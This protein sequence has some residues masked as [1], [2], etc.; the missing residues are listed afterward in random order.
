[1]ELAV[2]ES[3][4]RWH[5]LG[6][7]LSPNGYWTPSGLESSVVLL[8]LQIIKKIG[9]KISE[10]V[11]AETGVVYGTLG[12]RLVDVVGNGIVWSFVPDPELR[13]ALQ[14]D[15]WFMENLNS[16][17]KEDPI[18]DPVYAMAT[19]VLIVNS[20]G[21]DRVAEVSIW[22]ARGKPGSVMILPN[23]SIDDIRL[24]GLVNIPGT[25]LVDSSQTVVA[26]KGF[27]MDWVHQIWSGLLEQSV[28]EV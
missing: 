16:C 27:D 8:I 18:I 24:I 3:L 23:A 5:G 1:M 4:D 15:P 25:V 22:H 19:D 2:R 11:V 13:V 17:V 9:E 14:A 7:S 28:P 12:R 10:L 6:E 20:S 21:P 26:H